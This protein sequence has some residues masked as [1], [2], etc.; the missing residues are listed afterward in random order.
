LEGSTARA[1][2]PHATASLQ[3]V[4]PLQVKAAEKAALNVHKKVNLQA[5]PIRQYL[6]RAQHSRCQSMP[7]NVRITDSASSVYCHIALCSML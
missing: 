4:A 7:A 3:H 1:W 5:A 2:A 6:V